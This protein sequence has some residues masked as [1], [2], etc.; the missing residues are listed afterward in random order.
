MTPHPQEA[1][2]PDTDALPRGTLEFQVRQ[3]ILVRYKSPS[4]HVVRDQFR[5][6]QEKAQASAFFDEC[7]E[8]LRLAARR[9]HP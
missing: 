3:K 6:P 1:L 4:G 7:Y 5:N 8:K 9:N 2:L